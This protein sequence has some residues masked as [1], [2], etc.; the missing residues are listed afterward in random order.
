[1]IE[2]IIK[3]NIDDRILKK[4]KDIL[5]AGGIVAYPT[6]TSW[7]IGCSVQSKKGIE[8]LRKLKGN[9]QNY[10]LTMICSK[11]SQINEVAE[12]ND[13]AFKIIKK[14][15]PGPYVFVL[16]ALNNIEK[17]VNMKRIEIGVRIPANPVSI[18]II[19]VLGS[20]LFSITASKIMTNTDWW[21]NA[22]AE[23]NLFECGWELEEIKE[24]DL[25]LDTGEALPKVLSSVIDMTEDEIQIIRY[26]IGLI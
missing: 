10:T 26:G 13:F 23:E 1:M 9:F 6:D 22:Y 5:E 16:K 4:A 17:K 3:N 18:K 21:D 12:L 11:I 8:K 20:P 2:Y 25:I 24:I 7:G 19:E 14:Y 15:T